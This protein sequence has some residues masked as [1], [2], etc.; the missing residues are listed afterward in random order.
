MIRMR[1]VKEISSEEEFHLVIKNSSK[2]LIIDYSKSKCRPCMRAAPLY[3]QLSE[4]YSDKAD[5]YKVDADSWK[6]AMA[7]M[8]K[9]GIKSVPTFQVWKDGN[10]VEAI[11]GSHL[12][13]VEKRI[14]QG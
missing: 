12:D 10:V 7:L 2:P 9:Q 8:K 14:L 5:F 11:Q 3:E 13:E 6:E 4:K 1:A